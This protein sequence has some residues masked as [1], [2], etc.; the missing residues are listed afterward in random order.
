MAIK[1]GQLC[2]KW[3]NCAYSNWVWVR[4]SFIGDRELASCP[5]WSDDMTSSAFSKSGEYGDQGCVRRRLNLIWRSTAT[6]PYIGNGSPAV[7]AFAPN[8][9]K[10]GFSAFLFCHWY[11]ATFG[12][13]RAIAMPSYA[14]V[15]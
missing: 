12:V 6:F 10:T 8:G 14:H 9:A 1:R 2:S 15:K 3:R 13:S 4:S 7:D 5:T 11:H